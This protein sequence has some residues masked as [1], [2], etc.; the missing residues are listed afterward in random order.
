MKRSVIRIKPVQVGDCGCCSD[1]PELI[2]TRGWLLYLYMSYVGDNVTWHNRNNAH[3]R[4]FILESPLGFNTQ[5]L[6]LWRKSINSGLLWV[7]SWLATG[8]DKFDHYPWSPRAAWTYSKARP[9]TNP[10]NTKPGE[11]LYRTQQCWANLQF[12]AEPEWKRI[13]V[14]E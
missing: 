3:S 1:N 9:L 7:R 2:I 13:M 8:S 12:G 6:C 14:R 10:A 4:R 5:R 11:L